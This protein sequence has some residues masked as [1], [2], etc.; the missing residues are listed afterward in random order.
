M[1]APATGLDVTPAEA[2]DKSSI[3]DSLVGAVPDQ[4]IA[5]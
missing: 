2:G 5:L 1:S 4:E 3:M